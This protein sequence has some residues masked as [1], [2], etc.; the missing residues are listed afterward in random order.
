L[1]SDAPRR[2]KLTRGLAKIPPPS[3]AGAG[4]KRG[5]EGGYFDQHFGTLS[6]LPR[7]NGTMVST[8]ARVP[9]HTAEEVNRQIRQETED[10]LAYFADHTEEI[11]TRLDELDREWDVERTIEANAS[12]LAFTGVA[13]GATLDR[14]WLAL[15]ALVTAFLFQHA[16]QGWCPPVPI[17]RR[18][19]FRTA[20]EINRERYALKAL[21]GDFQPIHAA[22]NKLAAVITAV[23]IRK[24]GIADNRS[25]AS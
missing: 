23:G 18:M 24:R 7:L 9:K 10:R 12:I 13:L 4:Q 22:R 2:P 6:G 25:G 19:G 17:L 3:S 11:A 1:N 16:V 8:R 5:P 14:R 20:D 21:R 15:P